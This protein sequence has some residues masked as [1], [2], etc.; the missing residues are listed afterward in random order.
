[1]QH[2]KLTDEDPNSSFNGLFF[3]V[4]LFI[5]PVTPVHVMLQTEGA[6]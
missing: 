6:S 3:F 5:H 1:M 2:I 4:I